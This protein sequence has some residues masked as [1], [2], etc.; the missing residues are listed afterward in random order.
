MQLRFFFIFLRTSHFFSLS[1]SALLPHKHV[2]APQTSQQ[3]GSRSESSRT[4]GA[5]SN[6]PPAETQLQCRHDFVHHDAA[7]AATENMTVDAQLKMVCRTRSSRNDKQHAHG[8]EY[9]RIVEDGCQLMIVHTAGVCR[10][11][12]VEFVTLCK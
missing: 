7:N 11:L 12:L 9:G 2:M 5:S 3:G 1:S 10:E 8:Y 4:T 6:T